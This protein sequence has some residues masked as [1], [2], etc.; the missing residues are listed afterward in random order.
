MLTRRPGHLEP[1][2]PRQDSNASVAVR[3]SERKEPRLPQA[4]KWIN[5][6]DSPL[7][8]SD[9]ARDK[10]LRF[11]LPLLGAW[12]TVDRSLAA[13]D[14]LRRFGALSAALSALLCGDDMGSNGILEWSAD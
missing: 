10:V 9:Q 7:S 4:K 6:Y 11:L 13:K 1:W 12:A 5:E 3:H 14:L 2:L 8:A